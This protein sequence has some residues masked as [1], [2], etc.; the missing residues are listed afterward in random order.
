MP[1]GGMGARFGRLGALPASPT[2]TVFD[3]SVYGIDAL[4]NVYALHGTARLLTAYTGNLV[5]LRRSSDSVERDWGYST[6]TGFLPTGDIN[7]WLAGSTAYVTTLYDQSGNSRDA[8]QTTTTLQPQLVLSGAHPVL[9]FPVATDPAA[10]LLVQSATGFTQ[11]S[12][13]FSLLAV[14]QHTGTGTRGVMIVVVTPTVSR[15]LVRRLAGTPDLFTAGGRKTDAG[16]FLATPGLTVDAAWAAEISRF[17]IANSNLHHRVDAA[18]ESKTDFHTDGLIDNTANQGIA[19]GAGNIAGFAA[20]HGYAS[21]Y[22][23]ISDVLTDPEDSS[24]VTS[25]AA[26][27]L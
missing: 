7:T 24:L 8:T 19:L 1:F 27:K 17:D 26:L 13:G 15:A 20:F 25:L 6:S 4:D 21:A 18:T 23:L 2:A 14:R 11:N 16:S 3:P 22:A 10:H 9:Y 12:G 5:R